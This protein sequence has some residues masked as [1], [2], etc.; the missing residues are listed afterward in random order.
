HATTPGGL[1]HTLQAWPAPFHNLMTYT[2]WVFALWRPLPDLARSLDPE[3]W[4]TG[5]PAL[6]VMGLVAALDREARPTILFGLAWW[7]VGL[8]P[9]LPLRNDAYPHYL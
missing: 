5:V 1:A 3:A 9:M 6:F 7:F 2:H 8:L 4:R